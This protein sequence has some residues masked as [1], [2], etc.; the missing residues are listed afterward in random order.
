MRPQRPKRRELGT[1]SIPLPPYPGS[2]A[3]LAAATTF[4]N[5]ARQEINER[6]KFR[7][8]VIIAIIAATF[9]LLGFINP[10]DAKAA[11]APPTP[12]GATLA[13]IGLGLFVV[14]VGTGFVINFA[15]RYCGYQNAKI[16]EL[17]Y[18]ITS[19]PA[20]HLQAYGLHE[21]LAAPLADGRMATLPEVG[22][23]G[24]AHQKLRG[25][26][27]HWDG[28]AAAAMIEQAAI[29]KIGVWPAPPGIRAHKKEFSLDA[30]YRMLLTQ[31]SLLPLA[32]LVIACLK[33]WSS[34]PPRFLEQPEAIWFALSF[35]VAFGIPFHVRRMMA[36][37]EAL[38]NHY[39]D[40]RRKVDA[41]SMFGRV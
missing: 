20:F 14:T 9:A 7:D 41:G 36:R 19:E 33:I 28:W 22:R 1:L 34:I 31:F 12:G 30:V 39:S 10:L 4:Y 5:A 13:S 17:G 35:A 38:K 32:I 3:S 37:A 11:L 27:S 29:D 25:S 16:A 23:I 24:D 2:P 8:Q 26:F 6:V 18:F 21:L 15:C 40:L